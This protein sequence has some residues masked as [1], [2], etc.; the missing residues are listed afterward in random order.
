MSSTL[1]GEKKLRAVAPYYVENSW[2]ALDLERP[3]ASCRCIYR[4]GGS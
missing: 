2:Q 1:Y 3:V 4:A